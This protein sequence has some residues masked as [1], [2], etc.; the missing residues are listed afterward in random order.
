M[1]QKVFRTAALDQMRREINRSRYGNYTIIWSGQFALD[2]H[3]NRPSVDFSE[4]V[5]KAR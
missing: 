5:V 4:S 1:I 2:V 3:I